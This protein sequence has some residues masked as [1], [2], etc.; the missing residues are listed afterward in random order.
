MTTKEYIKKYELDKNDKF[1]HTEFVEDLT[2]DLIALLELN[3][4]Q[5]N[6]KGFGN[7]VKCIKMKWD[8]I[9]NKTVGQLPEKLWKF[10]W[11]TVVVKLKEELCPADVAKRKEQAEARK[12]EW[13]QRKKQKEWEQEQFNDYFW[14]R[15][16]YSFLFTKKQIQIPNE[17][18][19]LLGLN[20][21]CEI[22]DIKS[23]YKKLSLKHHP[24]KGG[25]QEDFIKLTDAKN[26]CIQWLENKN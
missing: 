19:V 11:A 24:D 9:N 10:Y 12:K 2:S 15:N 14:G 21:D 25:K 13:E 17:S 6:I 26:K 20:S 3:K 5:D 18:F 23:S 4:A 22:N 1:N 8:A 7:A 16:F